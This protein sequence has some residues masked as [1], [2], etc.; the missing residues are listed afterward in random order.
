[1]PR[2]QELSI[3]ARI[4]NTQDAQPPEWYAMD[5]QHLAR[6]ISCCPNLEGL[7]IR[8]VME[9]DSD[10]SV[11]RQLLRSCTSLEIGGWGFT[12]TAAPVVAQL[13]QLIHLE[14]S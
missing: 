1:M 3:N 7:D 10:L 12:A 6:V 11:L 8:G 9:E 13:T 4:E 5:S 14:W 2:L